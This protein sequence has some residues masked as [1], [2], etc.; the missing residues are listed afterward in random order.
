MCQSN[1]VH[2]LITKQ[3]LH[4][5]T[6]LNNSNVVTGSVFGN[7]Y[8]EKNT[9]VISGVSI[10]LSVLPTLRHISAQKTAS[11]PSNPNSSQAI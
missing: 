5:I 6:G 10:M 1:G 9:A 7:S 8:E 3:T 2:S 4:N 11:F